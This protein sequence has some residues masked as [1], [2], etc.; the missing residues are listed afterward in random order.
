MVYSYNGQFELIVSTSKRLN[1]V[2]LQV[3]RIELSHLVGKTIPS[4]FFYSRC[5]I[6]A[7][8]TR[9]MKDTRDPT[10]CYHRV[11]QVRAASPKNLAECVEHIEVPCQ[12][13]H[14]PFL[15][16]WGVSITEQLLGRTYYWDP[17]MVFEE[18]LLHPSNDSSKYPGGYS[19]SQT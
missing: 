14:S 12:L 4:S 18:D 17:E 1:I 13:D 9:L 15:N 16:L 19:I 11:R 10:K 7:V 3:P 8:S 2:E 5:P 6:C